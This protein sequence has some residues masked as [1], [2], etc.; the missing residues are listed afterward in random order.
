MNPGK[1]FGHRT[2]LLPA[3]LLMLAGTGILGAADDAST[4]ANSATASVTNQSQTDEIANLKASLAAQQKQLQM[5]QQTLQSQQALLEKALGSKT[6]GASG[7]SS[8]TT[9]T[10]IGQ[11]AST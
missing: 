6:E 2:L 1:I 11:V 5:L 7:A 9:F 4:A 10:G 8:G 3:T